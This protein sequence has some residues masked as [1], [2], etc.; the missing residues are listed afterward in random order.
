MRTHYLLS[1]SWYKLSLKDK[2]GTH[3]KNIN[4]QSMKKILMKCG[5]KYEGMYNADNNALQCF[6]YFCSAGM[7]VFILRSA[8]FRSS[9]YSWSF[10]GG[11]SFHRTVNN[12]S[13]FFFF[14]YFLVRILYLWIGCFD[15]SHK[16]IVGSDN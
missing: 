4:I 13:L 14:F 1:P 16:L 5:L 8:V 9:L 12:N 3:Q 7:Y 2:R 6:H 15:Q 11:K 10:S